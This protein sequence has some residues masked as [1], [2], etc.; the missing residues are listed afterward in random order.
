MRWSRLV[1]IGL[2]I[3][4]LAVLLLIYVL[5]FSEE[6]KFGPFPLP[7]PRPYGHMDIFTGA[8]I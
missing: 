6:R 8:K 1:L 3:G 4:L 7:I 5:V 2:L